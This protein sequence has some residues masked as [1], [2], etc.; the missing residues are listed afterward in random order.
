[1][2]ENQKF[3]DIGHPKRIWAVG[4]I[5]GDVERLAA[6]HAAGY[7]RSGAEPAAGANVAGRAHP[8]GADHA[9]AFFAGHRAGT[10]EVGA[11][12]E[13]LAASPRRRSGALEDLHTQRRRWPRDRR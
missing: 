3:A 2:S 13:R 9:P 11:H 5:H 7:Q 6:L 10:A 4:A 1:M 8:A 12:A